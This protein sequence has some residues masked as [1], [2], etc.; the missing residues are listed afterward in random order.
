[1]LMSQ[2]L[3]ITWVFLHSQLGDLGQA[4]DFYDLPLDVYK[5]TART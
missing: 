4:R 1:M 5:K 2:R 3:T